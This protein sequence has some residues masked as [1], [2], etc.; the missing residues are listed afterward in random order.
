MSEFEKD[1]KLEALLSPFITFVTA[2]QNL[3]PPSTDDGKDRLGPWARFRSQGPRNAPRIG[4]S[5]VSR[6]G[7]LPRTRQPQRRLRQKSTRPR[8]K[9]FSEYTRTRAGWVPRRGS[10]SE[11]RR[12][13][14]LICNSA[15][16]IHGCQFF[17]PYKIVI[18]CRLVRG[19]PSHFPDGWASVPGP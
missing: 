19:S 7:M 13:V 15:T 4:R 17:D 12:R 10:A 9:T 18:F 2:L 8:A 3:E 16:E 5:R 1:R 11:L 14:L 6:G